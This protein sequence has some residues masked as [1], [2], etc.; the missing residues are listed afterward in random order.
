M[1]TELV[2]EQ[3][4]REKQEKIVVNRRVNVAMDKVMS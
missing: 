4:A 1:T 3:R 2:H